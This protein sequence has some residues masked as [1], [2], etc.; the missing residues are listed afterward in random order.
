MSTFV[1]KKLEYMSGSQV[2]LHH[3][4]REISVLD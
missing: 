1:E 3:L 2:E 4:F